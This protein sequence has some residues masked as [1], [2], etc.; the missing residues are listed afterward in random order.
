MKS[1]SFSGSHRYCRSLL[2]ALLVSFAARCNG[3][4]TSS[5]VR[6]AEKTVEMPLDSDVFAVP[7]GYNS[8]QQ[9]IY[10]IEL[11]VPEHNSLFDISFCLGFLI[12]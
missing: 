8:P 6:K 4:N 7:P 11:L 9:V 2:L 1:S 3:G 10:C 5:F 12:L